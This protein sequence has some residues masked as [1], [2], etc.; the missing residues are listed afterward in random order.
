MINYSRYDAA[1]AKVRAR[2]AQLNKTAKDGW[3][4]MANFAK[5]HAEFDSEINAA[6][7]DMYAQTPGGNYKSFVQ[8]HNPF[9]G[10][11]ATSQAAY[12]QAKYRGMSDSQIRRAGYKGDA[13]AE[14]VANPARS[15]VGPSKYVAP[16]YRDNAYYAQVQADT[17]EPEP[18]APAVPA[19]AQQYQKTFDEKVAAGGGMTNTTP[20]STAGRVSSF[21][22]TG[23]PTAIPE[24]AAGTLDT[25]GD[26]VSS[27][28][29]R[30]SLFDGA[31]TPRPEAVLG[32]FD[33]GGD[34]VSSGEGLVTDSPYDTSAPYPDRDA[35]GLV[36]TAEDPTSG[37]LARDQ[38]VSFMKSGE[39]R[40]RTNRVVS[41]RT[42]NRDGGGRSYYSSRFG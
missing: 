33:T 37:S 6:K 25:G 26:E 19:A 1:M 11:R 29:G 9:R 35:N 12:L 36:I 31:G 22:E 15:T 28:G 14:A 8:Y 24:A 13:I 30:I 5:A 4:R 3:E 7:K 16:E 42:G 20:I 40:G 18:Q 41:N 17:P 2:Q 23:A 10:S 32:T 34:Q 39:K 38:A 21:D 27:S